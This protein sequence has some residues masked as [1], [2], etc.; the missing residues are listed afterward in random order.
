MK[1]MTCKHCGG[2]I[3]VGD[4]VCPHCGIPLPPNLG[5]F[6]QRKFVIFFIA[7]VI[8]CFVMIVWLPPDWTRFIK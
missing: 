4:P 8:F 7:L 3:S 6:S 2:E 1:K 5:G